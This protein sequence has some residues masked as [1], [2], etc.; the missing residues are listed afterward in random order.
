[1]SCNLDNSRI[2]PQE[3]H[4]TFGNNTRIICNSKT[5]TQWTHNGVSKRTLNYIFSHVVLIHSGL[6][7]CQGQTE[8]GYTLVAIS[9]LY[10]S[11][12]LKQ[13]TI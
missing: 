9:K 12:R 6:Y 2:Y 11:C 7:E 8:T 1:M 3:L 4:L 10:V 5:Y 13:D